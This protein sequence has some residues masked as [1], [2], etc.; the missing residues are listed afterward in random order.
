MDKYDLQHS[1]ETMRHKAAKRITKEPKLSFN[2]L[3]WM[4]LLPMMS[5]SVIPQMFVEEWTDDQTTDATIEV[6]QQFQERL[7]SITADTP[8]IAQSFIGDVLLAE[9]L[10]EDQA[11]DI[12]NALKDRAGD[13]DE[14][15]GYE[16]GNIGDLRECRVENNTASDIAACTVEQE[17]DDNFVRGMD[18]SLTFLA[19]LI[20]M[21][22]GAGTLARRS[23]N[24]QRWG[25]KQ[26][27]H[28]KFRH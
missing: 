28:P 26:P 11:D 2:E 25:G 1:F 18:I 19:L 12:L 24:V 10:S 21:G 15:A 13:V 8:E 5:V 14:I 17:K 20:A 4:I 22:R 16:I 23:E 27:S 9:D 7:S 3:N 6:E